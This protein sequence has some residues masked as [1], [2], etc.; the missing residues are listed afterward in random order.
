[1]SA[2]ATALADPFAR[3]IRMG[4]CRSGA[5]FER[6]AVTVLNLRGQTTVVCT[7]EQPSPVPMSTMQ[8][9]SP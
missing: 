4:P 8:D 3:L 1:M 9:A 6:G 2:P 7:E 5:T